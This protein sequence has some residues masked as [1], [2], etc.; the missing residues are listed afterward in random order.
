VDQSGTT[1]QFSGAGG[2]PPEPQAPQY[3]SSSWGQLASSITDRNGNQ[4][5]LNGNG[6]GYQDP[7]GRTAVSWTG[8]GNSGDQISVSGLGGPVTLYWTTT[9]VSFP[10]GGH[11]VGQSQCSLLGN[12]S[13]LSV[14]D[15]ID[16]PNGQ[17]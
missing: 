4:I 9:P 10:E 13:N 7:T 15:E 8:I 17:K 1:Y 6:K 14:V 5:T 11:N 2:Q 3:Y 16:L 12:N